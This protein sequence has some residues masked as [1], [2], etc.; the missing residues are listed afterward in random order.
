MAGPTLN[1]VEL[2]DME[3]GLSHQSKEILACLRD[4]LKNYME[5]PSDALFWTEEVVKRLLIMDE[6]QNTLMAKIWRPLA[7]YDKAE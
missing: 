2:D 6:F 7:D 3:N 1:D 5:T 4:N